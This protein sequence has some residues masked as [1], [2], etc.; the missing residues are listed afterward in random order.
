MKS[1][2]ILK[3]KIPVILFAMT[4]GI[5]LVLS[6]YLSVKLNEVQVDYATEISNLKI[7]NE[8][9]SKKI[10]DQQ[11]KIAPYMAVLDAD[12][13][14]ASKYLD[15]PIPS[16][17]I[18]P[19]TLFGEYL[20]IP[21]YGEYYQPSLEQLEFLTPTIDTILKEYRA[22]TELA[23]K[24]IGKSK[25]EPYT[26]TSWTQQYIGF[27]NIPTS[28]KVSTESWRYSEARNRFLIGIYQYEHGDIDKTQ[29]DALLENYE[30]TKVDVAN[31]LKD[32]SF[33]D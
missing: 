5:L 3:N 12:L 29:L 26:T 4:T 20:S 21:N 23:I 28:M 2:S 15:A 33:A 16:D 31:A 14:E 27:S 17:K 10:T 1:S 19:Q 25:L 6:I 13:K 18:S 11:D 9:L 30:K 8:I 22:V 32:I 7:E 24:E